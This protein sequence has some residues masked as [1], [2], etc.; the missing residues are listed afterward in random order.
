MSCLRAP[1]DTYP[2]VTSSWPT[3]YP[4]ETTVL[5]DDRIPLETVTLDAQMLNEVQ[6]IPLVDNLYDQGMAVHRVFRD[7]AHSIDED[8]RRQDRVADTLHWH[9]SLQ[10]HALVKTWPAVAGVTV[11][12]EGVK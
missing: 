6:L 3:R 12:E 5:P 1:D 10:A 7:L 2:Y 4:G 9:W 11:C 8:M